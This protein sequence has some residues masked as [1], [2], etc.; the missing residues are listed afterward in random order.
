MTVVTAPLADKNYSQF[1]EKD[2]STSWDPAGHEG[3]ELEG[4][5]QNSPFFWGGWGRDVVKENHANPYK[6][7]FFC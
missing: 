1:D 5:G 3:V 7:F 6:L 2:F 4:W